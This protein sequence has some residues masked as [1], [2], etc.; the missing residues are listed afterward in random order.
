MINLCDC[1]DDIV[2]KIKCKN[3]KCIDSDFC[4]YHKKYM[5]N[6]Y[7]EYK[8]HNNNIK[9]MI[10]NINKEDIYDLLKIYNYASEEYK[11]RVQYKSYLYKGKQLNNEHN[12]AINYINDTIKEYEYLLENLFSLKLQTT[13]NIT[14]DKQ[15][16]VDINMNNILDEKIE[17]S[18]KKF[19]TTKT[20]IN[21]NKTIFKE[22]ERYIQ[23]TEKLKVKTLNDIKNKSD[24]FLRGFDIKTSFNFKYYDIDRGNIEYNNMNLECY[25]YNIIINLCSSS[26]QNI[27]KSFIIVTKIFMLFNKEIVANFNLIDLLHMNNTMNNQTHNI[28]K[29]LEI[30]KNYL[31][32]KEKYKDYVFFILNE[33]NDLNLLFVDRT[34]HNELSDI[35]KDMDY[36]TTLLL[37]TKP[38]KEYNLYKLLLNNA[39]LSLDKLKKDI[40]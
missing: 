40:I 13:T 28:T 3:D 1:Y 2:Q 17:K 10:N 15:I 5:H 18:F 33:N 21:E 8:T 31:K 16:D 4:N 23:N 14:N 25:L 27:S 36:Y 32:N 20:E 24:N 34:K 11:Y 26:Y 39:I 19:K 29:S 30:I 9:K 12:E 7:K 38:N 37:K 35:L 6:I 22:I